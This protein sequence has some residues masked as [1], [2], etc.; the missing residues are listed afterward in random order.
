V[1]KI[2]LF[3]HRSMSA[4]FCGKPAAT[5]MSIAAA[6]NGSSKRHK[7][8]QQEDGSRTQAKEHGTTK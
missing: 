3:V 4:V 1:K 8:T 6:D 7:V 5:A 2:A